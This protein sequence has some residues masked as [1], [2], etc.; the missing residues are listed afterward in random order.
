MLGEG[1]MWQV[2]LPRVVLELLMELDGKVERTSI[3][4]LGLGLDCL[5][6]M[7]EVEVESKDTR[8]GI[9]VGLAVIEDSK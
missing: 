5:R 9:L 2:R 8:L 6:R 1:W 4:W 7:E 3:D